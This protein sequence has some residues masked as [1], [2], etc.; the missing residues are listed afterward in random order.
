MTR[1]LTLCIAGVMAIAA[2]GATALEPASDLKS[3][4]LAKDP[5]V[6]VLK[7]EDLVPPGY[8]ADDLMTKYAEQIKDMSDG[9]PRAQ[10]LADELRAKWDSAP[11]VKALNNKTVK[12]SG[13]LVALEGDGAAVSEFLL[14]PY[15]GACIHVPPPPSNQIVLVRMGKKPHKI[16]RVFDTVAVTGRMRTEQARHE[17]ASAAYVIDATKVETQKQ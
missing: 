4:E 1:W 2:A 17:L 13:F 9:D 7:W 6:R 12:L 8:R 16:V 11:V 14:V 5:G 15:F 10:R 3:S